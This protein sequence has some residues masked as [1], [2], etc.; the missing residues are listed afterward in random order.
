[1]ALWLVGAMVFCLNL[2][3]GYWWAKVRKFSMPWLLAVHIPV[4]LIIALRA[5]SGIGW[6]FV[7]FPV[8]IGAF[9]LG[10]YAGGIMSRLLNHHV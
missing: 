4:P 5:Y 1:M 7:T 8:L 9:L 3:F 2:P 10:Q 6:R